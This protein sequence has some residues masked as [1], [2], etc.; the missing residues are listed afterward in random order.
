MPL[1]LD[2]LHATLRDVPS[3]GVF[4]NMSLPSVSRFGVGNLQLVAL[5]NDLIGGGVNVLARAGGAATISSLLVP[6]NTRTRDDLSA[7]PFVKELLRVRTRFITFRLG[8]KWLRKTSRVKR[9]IVRPL[10]IFK[11]QRGIMGVV[12]IFS[13]RA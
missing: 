5:F 9:K 3:L 4:N 8:P 10:T 1:E 13:Q 11:F 2:P 12:K 7:F 6:D